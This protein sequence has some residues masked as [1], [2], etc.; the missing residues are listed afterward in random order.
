MQHECPITVLEKKCFPEYQAQYPADPGP[1]LCFNAGE[2]G[3]RSRTSDIRRRTP[4]PAEAGTVY[5]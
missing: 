3:W 5:E 2:A 4:T 1:G